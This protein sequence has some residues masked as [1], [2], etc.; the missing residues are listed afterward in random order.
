MSIGFV[1]PAAL[2][3]GMPFFSLLLRRELPLPEGR[4]T[5]ISRLILKEVQTSFREEG[6]AYMWGKVGFGNACFC[7]LNAEINYAKFK[8]ERNNLSSSSEWLKATATASA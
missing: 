1:N 7:C 8:N 4:T 3:L 6:K 5:Y 2:P